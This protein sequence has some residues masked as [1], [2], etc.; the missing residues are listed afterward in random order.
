MA[1]AGPASEFDA[2]RV[3][4]LMTTGRSDAQMTPPVARSDEGPLDA[5]AG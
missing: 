2:Q 1:G 4:R 5:T 3:V